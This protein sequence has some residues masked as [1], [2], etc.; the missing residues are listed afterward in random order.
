M[1]CCSDQTTKRQNPSLK[2]P[3]SDLILSSLTDVPAPCAHEE[4]LSS[5]FRVHHAAGSACH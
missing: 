2:S 3:G 4:T 5:L 1:I